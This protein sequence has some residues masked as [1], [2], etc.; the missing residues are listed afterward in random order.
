MN[1]IDL[2]EIFCDEL[3]C[4]A[5]TP[6]GVILKSDFD[7]PSLSGAIMINNLIIKEIEKIELKSN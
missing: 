4:Y 7:H 5:I 6:S 2:N 1:I 3:K